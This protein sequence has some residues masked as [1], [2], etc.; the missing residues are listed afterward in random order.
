MRL[1]YHCMNNHLHLIHLPTET[2]RQGKRASRNATAT[3]PGRMQEDPL[4][5]A[6]HLREDRQGPEISRSDRP[7]GQM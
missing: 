3:V 4:R 5:K 1:F 7:T 2:P 6:A